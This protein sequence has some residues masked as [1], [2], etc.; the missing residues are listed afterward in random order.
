VAVIEDDPVMGGSLEQRLALERYVVDWYRTGASAVAA[1]RARGV[2]AVVCDIRLPDRGGEELYEE[3][4]PM[5]PGV[6]VI[7]ITG[8]G[9]IDQAVRLV[10]AGAADYLT[11][12]FEVGALLDRLGGLVGEPDGTGELGGS[13]AMRSLEAMLRRIAEL[14]ST[15]LITGE[16]GAGKE[17]AAR[18][19]HSVS[20]R[21]AKPFVAV[22]CAA[23]PD[24]LIESE[25]FGH[26]RGA[27][28][29]ADRTHEGYLERVRGGTLF[30]DEIGDL[31]QATQTK[32]LRVL[33]ERQFTRLG[34]TRTS[35]LDGRV[36]C[37]T[38]RDLAAMV[39]DGRFRQDLFYRVSVIPVAVPAL[40]DRKADILPL[41]ETMAAEFSGQFGRDVRGISPEARRRAMDHPWPGNVRELRNRVERAV[42]LAQGPLLGAGDLF[43]ER[44]AEPRTERAGRSLA[45]VRLQA[46]TRHIQEVLDEAGGQVEEAARRLGVSRSSLFDRLRRLRK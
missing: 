46:E 45:D 31:P 7:F 32:L 42:A 10:K 4:R 9:Q 25:L 26:E 19:A 34:G 20:S 36:A 43:P 13:E 35:K 23:I 6:P 38:H 28:T 14:D 33:Q 37:A 1:V 17:V 21:A 30:L 15:L 2:D 24:S 27:F 18:F 8:Y 39:A 16:T 44:G 12:P 3:L 22:N 11:K 40:R 5:L 29:G 41:M